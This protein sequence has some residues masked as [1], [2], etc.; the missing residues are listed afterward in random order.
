[1]SKDA[2]GKGFNITG[3]DSSFTMKIGLRFQTLFDS[4]WSVREDDL[5]N[6]GAY[7]SNFLIRRSRLKFNGFVY[8]PKLKYKVELGLSNRDIG[9]SNL[10]EV[11]YGSRIILDA[12]IDWN[13]YKNFSLKAGQAK[14]PGN[15]ERV[16]SS[17]NLQFV[18]RSLLNSKYNIDRDMGLQL[19]HHFKIGDSFIIKEV[20]A[21]S[22]G[23]G[24]NI[25]SGNLGGYDYTF[26]L[27]ML[28]F[29]KFSS[30]GDYVGSAIKFEKKPKLAIG[31]TYDINDNAV[32]KRGQGGSFIK[33]SEGNYA[34]RTL[35]TFFADL[36]FKYKG[37]SIMGE[38]AIKNTSN[39]NPYIIDPFND[40]R[41]GPYYIGNGLNIQAGWM[42]NN[43]L[44]ISG[45]YTSISPELTTE[46]SLNQYTIGVSKF[47][48]GHKLKVQGDVSYT[49]NYYENNTSV[50]QGKN[51][52]LMWRMQ[53]D[54][55]F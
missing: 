12:Y 10:E 48:V 26:R 45:R 13:F 11:K 42:F 51:D 29:G 14:L 20:I 40:D 39:G 16:I 33:D 17:A 47:I 36:M 34:G 21:F 41:L 3:K 27:E 37:L 22:Q 55:H 1:M 28:P 52:A 4:R 53:V 6:I 8:T 15:R 43:M 19:K 23:E 31:F 2:F 25:T 50:N 7:S 32:R 9:G 44:E 30:K 24:R 54:I 5:M 35:Y 18:D 38:Y 49:Q 46:T